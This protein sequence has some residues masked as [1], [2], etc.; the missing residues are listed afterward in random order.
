M[1]E[2]IAWLTEE[3]V[4]VNYEKVAQAVYKYI[5]LLRTSK[6]SEAIFNEIKALADIDFR[7]VEKGHA[8]SYVSDLA[9]QLHQPVPRDKV[10]SSQWLVEEFDEAG[11]AKLLAQLDVRNSNIAI[12]GKVLPP[13]IGDFDRTE[14]IYGTR[15]RKEKMSQEFIDEAL[16]GTLPELHLPAL[17]AFVPEDLH[18]EKID[19][20]QPREAPELIKQTGLSTMWYKKDDRYWVPRANVFLCLKSSV[21][22]MLLLVTVADNVVRIKS[23]FGSNS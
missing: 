20:K 2:K 15:Y 23:T 19:V 12:S 13:G 16:N 7:F 9:R 3:S 22:G 8:S 1:I 5:H 14:P 10:I 4:V 17:N 21:L 18:V 11:T 6:P